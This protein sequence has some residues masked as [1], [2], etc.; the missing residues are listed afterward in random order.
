MPTTLRQGVRIQYGYG[1]GPK[2]ERAPVPV[3]GIYASSIGLTYHCRSCGAV[4]EKRL[5]QCPACSTL[6]CLFDWE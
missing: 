1:Q 4:A 6:F 3:S 5:S 2:I